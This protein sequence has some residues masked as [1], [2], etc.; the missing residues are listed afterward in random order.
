MI[1]HLNPGWKQPFNVLINSVPRRRWFIFALVLLLVLLFSAVSVWAQVEARPTPPLLPGV[2]ATPGAGGS[3]TYT[4]SIESLIFFASLSLIPVLILMMTSF[5][6]I[7][8]VFSLLRQAMGVQNSPSNQVLIGLTLFL[9]FF[10]MSPVME[11]IYTEAYVPMANK[12]IG[13]SEA[14]DRGLVPLKAFMLRQTRET[15]LALFSKIANEELQSPETI[16]LK[17]LAPAYVISE[18]KT[19]FQIGF[20]IYIPFLVIDM[21][22]ASVLMSMGMM[23]MSPVIVSLPFKLMLFV[24]ADGWNILIASLVQTFR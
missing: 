22:V 20:V 15:D 23:M 18:L 1:T 10:I 8:I 13:F 16:P 6:R 19:A 14:V 9:T 21:A 12:E 3:M 2:T 17:I 4:A 24:L 11:T 7:I 5:L